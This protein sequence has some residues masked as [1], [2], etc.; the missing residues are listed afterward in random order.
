MTNLMKLFKLE[1]H[2]HT[3]QIQQGNHIQLMFKVHTEK[4]ISD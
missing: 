2:P 1:F 3:T 4:K